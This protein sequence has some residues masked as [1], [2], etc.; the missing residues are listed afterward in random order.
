MNDLVRYILSICFRICFYIARIFPVKDN[1]IIFSSFWGKKYGD[2][3]KYICNN[4]LQSDLELRWITNDNINGDS[5]PKKVKAVRHHSLRMIYEL[6]TSKIWIFNSAPP[7]YCIKRKKQFYIQTWHGSLALKKIGFASNNKS[8][9]R[10]K[11]I[12]HDVKMIDLLISNSKFTDEMYRRDFNYNGKILK[13]GSPRMDWLIQGN[14]DE[15]TIRKRIG[16]NNDNKILLYAP[17]FRDDGDLSVFDIDIKKILKACSAKFGGNWTCLVRLHPSMSNNT[18][19]FSYGEDIINCSGLGD[20]YEIM[21]IASIMITDYSSVMFEMGMLKKLVL[22]YQKD[23]NKYMND[24]GVYFKFDELPYPVAQNNAEIINIIKNVSEE[25]YEKHL[26]TFYENL[27][28][29]ENGSA[30]ECICNYI[31][32]NIISCRKKV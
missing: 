7:L 6:V 1:K 9:L 4:L 31:N 14:Y 13:C 11:I 23:Q 28:V 19:L 2:N 5:L 8:W 22:L 27:D 32:E 20:I 10:R 24:R 3:P 29:V 26:E 25:E 18:D 12:L 16:I 21:A 30:S 15:K 17:T